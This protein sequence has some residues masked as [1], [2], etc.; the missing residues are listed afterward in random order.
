MK[1][2]WMWMMLTICALATAAHAQAATDGSDGSD[3]GSGSAQVQ[4]PYAGSAQSPP[5]EASR[6]DEPAAPPK[7][8]APPPKP[9]PDI[10][11]P[12]LIATPTGWL[13][14]AA[15][16]Y[17]RTGLDTSGGFTTDER[18]GLGDVAEFGLSTLDDVRA[19]NASTDSP[20]A[21]QPYI[22]ASF[23]IGIAEDRLFQNQPGLVL[24]FRKSFSR[25]D[26]DVQS[27]IAELTLVASEHIGSGAA[28][29]IGAAF[30]DASLSGGSVD[31]AL[32]DRSAHSLIDQIRPFGGIEVWPF[33]RSEILADLAWAPV[34]CYTCDAP[35]QI[36]LSAELSWG[37]R[38]KA[39]PWLYLESGVH[40]FDI[41]QAKL[42]DAQIYGQVTFV[43]WG[44]RHAVDSIR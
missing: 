13:L 22:A 33:P 28:V 34:F 32:D 35:Q 38:Y 26:D 41:D 30:W 15:V 12:S 3:V 21:I 4:D 18:V 16:L 6:V 5:I 29:H 25:T 24:G 23:R 37:V 1:H 36:K 17:S 42:L 9:D 11:M 27:R 10:Y 2:R 19:K 39:T 40:V 31:T 44:L 7:P 43:T 20:Y 14:P 8:A